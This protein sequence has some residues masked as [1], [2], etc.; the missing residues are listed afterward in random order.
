MKLL[1]FV[2]IFVCYLNS[3][4]DG[5]KCYE[6][7]DITRRFPCD[8]SRELNCYEAEYCITYIY[9]CDMSVDYLDCGKTYYT[10]RSCHEN[11]ILCNSTSTGVHERNFSNGK[12][13]T[14]CCKGDL[15]NNLD[16]T[17]LMKLSSSAESLNQ[18]NLF[19]VSIFIVYCHYLI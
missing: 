14:S 2:V 3:K 17:E 15:C 12:Y 8:G 9:P 16:G 19:N 7:N 4:T 13:W 5:L 11:N 6:C 10:A 18:N 1:V